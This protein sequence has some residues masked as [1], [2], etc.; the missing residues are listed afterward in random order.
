[1]RT[2]IAIPNYNMRESLGRLLASLADEEFDD[3]YVLDDASDDG[4]ADYVAESFPTVTLVR[5]QANGGAPANRNRL[6]PYLDGTE[7]I[8][9][10]DADLELRSAGLVSTVRQWLSDD[11]LGLVGGLLVDR[12]EHPAPW[13]YGYTMHPVH[14]ARGHLLEHIDKMLT[15]GLPLQEHL[16][17]LARK[18]R[19]TLNLEIAHAA[20]AGRPVDW[21]SEGL[22]A[23]RAE[24]FRKIG[25][26]DE[27]F[28]YH[29]GQDLCL[30]VW[31]AGYAVR[32][33]PG[34]RAC[35]LEIDVRGESRRK[36]D[37][38]GKFLF[39][40]KHWGMSRSVFRRLMNQWLPAVAATASALPARIDAARARRSGP[41]PA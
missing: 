35:H 30:R 9:F 17:Q 18:H 24:L 19:D 39:Y 37:I 12:S 41:T 28:R 29:S 31:K 5:A 11:T 23:I 40:E 15:P 10:A 13:N 22:F 6:L 20:P 27:R 25:G 38:E 3:V 4:S 14:D 7:L 32:F 2:V 34:I 16:R 8:L 26:F 21:V 33:E 1:M 36:D